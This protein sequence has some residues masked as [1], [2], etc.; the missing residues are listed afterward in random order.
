MGK[1]CEG[2]PHARFDEGEMISSS[3]RENMQI[4]Q[5]NI[6]TKTRL[7]VQTMTRCTN[8]TAK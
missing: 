7:Q 1:P 5:P 6:Q 3:A 4:K 2:K 8:K